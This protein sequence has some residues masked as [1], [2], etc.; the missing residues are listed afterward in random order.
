MSD[1]RPSDP[2]SEGPPPE[3]HH[4]LAEEIKQ[5]IEEVVEHVPKP[6]RW[7]VGKLVR[8]ALLGLAGLVV[9][10]AVTAVLYVVNRTEWA[11]RELALM[12]NQA[13]VSRSDI[14]IEIGDIK[15]NPFTGVRVL[16]PRVRF[17]DSNLP[18]LMDAEEMRAG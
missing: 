18:P 13:L 7:T 5:E 8:L 3:E 9:L 4:G 2:T 17:R 6:I 11:A 16:K 12:V 1:E 14:T 15:G 10:V